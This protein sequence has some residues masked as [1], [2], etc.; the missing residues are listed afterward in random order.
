MSKSLMG[1]L[2]I[3][4]IPATA[5]IGSYIVNA[6]KLSDCDFESPYRCELI[7]VIGL[8]PPAQV[9]TVWFATDEEG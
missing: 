7:H 5:L 1:L 8:I 2:A 9:V 6:M 4:L 3:Y